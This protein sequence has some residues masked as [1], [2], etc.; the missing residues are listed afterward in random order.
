[1]FDPQYQLALGGAEAKILQV[2]DPKDIQVWVVVTAPQGHPDQ[3]TA[4]LKAP[5]VINLAARLGAQIILDDPKYG[6]KHSLP[7]VGSGPG[8][9]GQP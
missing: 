1:M 4:N 7:P 5:V 2:T 6:V 9:Q 3:I 8:G